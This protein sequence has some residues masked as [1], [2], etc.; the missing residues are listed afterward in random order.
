VA[1]LREIYATSEAAA[2]EGVAELIPLVDRVLDFAGAGIAA[3]P[4]RAATE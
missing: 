4:S 2:A 1:G 3:Q